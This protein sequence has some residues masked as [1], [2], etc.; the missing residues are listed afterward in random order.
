MNNK[1][2]SNLV[3]MALIFLGV[4]LLFS[5]FFSASFYMWLISFLEEYTT[6]PIFEELSRI[7]QE[8]LLIWEPLHIITGM[9]WFATGIVLYFK[10]NTFTYKFA[11][12]ISYL[13]FVVL[14]IGFSFSHRSV[15][16]YLWSLSSSFLVKAVIA[17]FVF[18][19]LF[20]TTGFLFFG[21]VALKYY[22]QS[23]TSEKA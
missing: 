11:A 12:T 5:G 6:K 19:G 13:I 8:V 4:D 3:P 1:S 2:L 21:W 23:F 14:L 10:R 9:L 17:F 20:F 16:V 7:S 22:L 15:I 18:F